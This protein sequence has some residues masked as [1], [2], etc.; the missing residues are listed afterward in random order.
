M[1]SATIKSVQE[2]N[3]IRTNW[4]DLITTD[5]HSI[6]NTG[7][8]ATY[9]WT[10]TLADIHLKDKEHGV[11]I[12][13]KNNTISAI[14]PYYI[15]DLR[16]FGIKHRTIHHIQELYLTR[17][18]LVLKDNDVNN[19]EHVIDSL[20]SKTII[21]DRL[22][23][24]IIE[25]KK[26]EESLRNLLTQHNLD[27]T[28]KEF[29]ESPYVA[30]PSSFNKTLEKL[31]KKFRY[32]ITSRI[33]KLEKEGPIKCKIYSS[34]E[35]SEEFLEKAYQ[36]ER[37][38]WK[39]TAGTSI[40]TND[41]QQRFYD[42]FTKLGAENNWLRGIIIS[43]NDE[44]IAYRY[45]LLFNNVFESLKISYVDKRKKYGPGNILMLETLKFLAQNNITHLD[46][47]GSVEPAKMKWTKHTYTQ[48]RVTIFNRNVKG[49]ILYLAE[50][51]RAKYS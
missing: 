41:Y 16:K 43:V 4:N 32:N 27:Y 44:P 51:T 7:I 1:I 21:W 49:R 15:M 12:C 34:P 3:A 11:I 26:N 42:S 17:S 29:S 25:N 23:F 9:E 40:T 50:K 38:S 22:I 8:C 37:S 39:E 48:K 18:G 46:L 6:D 24:N 13:K 14:F 2:C 30:P 35:E 36:I 10:K 31:D 5:K 28:I 19:F 47:S 20:K 33:K 45:G